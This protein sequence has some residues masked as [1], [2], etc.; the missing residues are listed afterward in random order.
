MLQSLTP[1]SLR[2]TKSEKGA[3]PGGDGVVVE[4]SVAVVEGPALHVLPAQ[5]HRVRPQVQAGR[6][7][8]LCMRTLPTVM[9]SKQAST[10][11]ASL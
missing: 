4:D 1:V 5:P 7:I 6:R 3:A 9:P 2:G 8:R 10:V 11:M